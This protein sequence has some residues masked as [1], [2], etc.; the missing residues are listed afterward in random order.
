MPEMKYTL[1]EIN[2]RQDASEESII[3]LKDT[4]IRNT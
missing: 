3:E 4:A 1:N 2:S